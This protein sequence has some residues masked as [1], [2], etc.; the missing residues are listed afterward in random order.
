MP[1]Q[2]NLLRTIAVAWIALFGT[3]LVVH[4]LLP[5]RT[6]LMNLPF[7]WMAVSDLLIAV[8]AVVLA[9]HTTWRGI[10]LGVGLAAIPL[11]VDLVN[12]FEAAWYLPGANRDWP[13]LVLSDVLT[14]G[15]VA[16]IWS[17]LFKFDSVQTSH[18]HRSVAEL[19]V[20]R[21]SL[22][23]TLSCVAYVILYV[24]AG[25]IVLPFVLD[26]YK[27]QSIPPIGTVLA[28]QFFARGPVFTAVCVLMMRLGNWPR[29][30]GALTIALCFA[31]ISGI[32]PLIVPNPYFPDA[33][34]WV[35]FGEVVGANLIFGALM[36]W[37]WGPRRGARSVSAMT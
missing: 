2:Q 34:R 29:P 23:L 13:W 14:F 15:L 33:V 36:A 16:I 27:T 30:R 24:I 4:A 21:A 11:A 5:S 32:A 7:A 10:R 19:S 17:N 35:H 1:S 22:R 37:L 20:A 28:M 26:F 8:V 31:T 3:S 6:P 9:R 18:Q 25:A 12:I